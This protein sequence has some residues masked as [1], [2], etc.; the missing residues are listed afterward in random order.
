[1]FWLLV[2]PQAAVGTLAQDLISIIVPVYNEART[3]RTVIDRLLTIDLPADREIIV[4][5][6][7]SSD[8]TRTVLDSLSGTSECLTVLHADENRGKGHAV[9]LGIGR[10]RGTVI[11]I[12]DA[13][14]ELDPAQLAGLVAPILRGEA[15][16]VYG[17]RFLEGS[18]GVPLLSRVANRGLTLVTNLLYGASL[19]DMETCYKIMRGDVARRLKLTANRFDI[20]P[21]ITAKL[22]LGGYRVAERAVT[23]SPRSRAAGKKIRWRDGVHAI[24][25]LV[26]CRIA[27]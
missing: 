25:V 7:G 9:R 16:V 24:R 19:T 20:E 17:S 14:L 6:D 12:Q 27:R 11:A 26:G 22:L 4:V 5:N 1:M 21:E 23:F 10:S 3:I 15:D 18:S 13:D 2:Y 8:A